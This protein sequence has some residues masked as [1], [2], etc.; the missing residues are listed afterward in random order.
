LKCL[1]NSLSRD[2]Y[3]V[4]IPHPETD[5]I[6]FRWVYDIYFMF[7]SYYLL[8]LGSQVSEMPAKFL[9]PGHLY[10]TI[11]HSET[12]YI[13]FQQFIIFLSNISYLTPP[14]HCPY[15]TMFSKCQHKKGELAPGRHIVPKREILLTI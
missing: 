12:D 5:C 4:T 11:P 3:L 14:I 15:T 9:D 1:Q 7:L 10:T 8:S 6:G 2:I 13:G